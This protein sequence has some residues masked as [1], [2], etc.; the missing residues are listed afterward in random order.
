MK[1][2]D[3]EGRS[4]VAA[5]LLVGLLTVGAFAAVPRLRSSLSTPRPTATVGNL[6][7]TSEDVTVPFNGTSWIGV[8]TNTFAGVSFQLWA[9]THPNFP[10]ELQGTGT[11]P[12]GIDLSFVVFANNT[13]FGGGPSNGSV[14]TWISPDGSFGLRWLGFVDHFVEVRLFVAAPPV[15]YDTKPVMLNSPSFSGTSAPVS[16]LFDGV[17]FRAA[18]AN[19]GSPAGP[20]LNASATLPSGATVDLALWAGPLVACGTQGDV[21]PSVLKNATCLESADSAHRVALVWDGYE[22]AT[23]LV[24]A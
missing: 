23:L 13:E 8:T 14:Q 4:A 3:T 1:A 7:Y 19:W 12:N 2:L 17:L 20:S 5:I 6:T 18:I 10:Y 11:Q 15:R 22:T 16:T 9:D 24:R 21:P